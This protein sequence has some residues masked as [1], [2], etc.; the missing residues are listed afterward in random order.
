ML[1]ALLPFNVSLE[2]QEEGIS[3]PNWSDGSVCVK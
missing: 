3:I 2:A 1:A